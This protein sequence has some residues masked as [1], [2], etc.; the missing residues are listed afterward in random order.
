MGKHQYQTK[1][2][3]GGVISMPPCIP[4]G[5]RLKMLVYNLIFVAWKRE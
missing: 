2:K 5:K 4:G 3:H 1:N